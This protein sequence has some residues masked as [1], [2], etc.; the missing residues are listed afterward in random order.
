MF[1]VDFTLGLQPILQGPAVVPAARFV[2]FVRPR[3]YAIHARRH[4]AWSRLR[5]WGAVSRASFVRMGRIRRRW[6]E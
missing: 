6:S 4:G 5:V 3:G 1:F 2:Q